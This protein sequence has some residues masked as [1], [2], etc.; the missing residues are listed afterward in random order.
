[1]E[2]RKNERKISG[3][4]EIAPPL[5]YFIVPFFQH[6]HS[7]STPR[8]PSIRQRLGGQPSFS[9]NNHN[10]NNNNSSS[11]GGGGSSNSCCCCCTSSS[12]ISSSSGSSSSTSSNMMM[13]MMIMMKMVSIRRRMR[14]GFFNDAF[15][16]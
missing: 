12:S 1:M 9:N 15:N 3:L 7:Q 13:V 2:E 14:V 11:S 4:T 16:C 10:N 6:Q 8:N 5:Q